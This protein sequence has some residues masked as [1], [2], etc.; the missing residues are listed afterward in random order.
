METVTDFIFLGSKITAYGDCS[1]EIAVATA[2]KSLQSCPILCDPID[3]GPPSS[4]VPGDSPGKN[5]GV[6][7]HDLLQENTS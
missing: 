4:S 5:T 1:H 2:A 3:G 6:G 7:C